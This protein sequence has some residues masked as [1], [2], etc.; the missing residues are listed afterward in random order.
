M[1]KFNPCI[2]CCVVYH[3]NINFCDVGR[4]IRTQSSMF[5]K[6]IAS[7]FQN[8]VDIPAVTDNKIPQPF[9]LNESSFLSKSANI[10]LDMNST[11]QKQDNTVYTLKY[12]KKKMLHDDCVL[13]L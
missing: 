6:D 8:E 3:K 12:L 5:V 11:I 10:A 13:P 7:C 2:F 9:A 1:T 4:S